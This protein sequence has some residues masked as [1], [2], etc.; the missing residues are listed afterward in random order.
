MR[1]APYVTFLSTEEKSIAQ[2][3]S[4]NGYATWH[5]GKW[6]LGKED[7]WTDKHGFDIIKAKDVILDKVKLSDYQKYVITIEGSELA[8]GGGGARCMTMPIAR[9]AGDW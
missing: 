8:R 1:S 5:I 2:A 7:Y 9:K 6:H 4:D 3:F